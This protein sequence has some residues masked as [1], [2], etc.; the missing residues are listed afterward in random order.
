MKSDL[1]TSHLHTEVQV[2]ATGF[3]ELG[4]PYLDKIGMNWR[5]LKD[6]DFFKSNIIR[7][8]TISQAQK[9]TASR[10]YLTE[11]YNAIICW[12]NARKIQREFNK[13]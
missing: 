11:K 9:D 5:C 1:N 7:F 12:L 8:S 4:Q 6:A 10:V 13:L 3:T 2:N